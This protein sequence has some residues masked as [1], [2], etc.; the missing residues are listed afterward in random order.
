[1]ALTRREASSGLLKISIYRRYNDEYMNN[2]TSECTKII[3]KYADIQ[4]TF[5]Q[6][7][8]KRERGGYFKQ[9]IGVRQKISFIY[10]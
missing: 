8:D 3:F 1:M 10:K 6:V 4:D 9:D 2:T 5:E 7:T